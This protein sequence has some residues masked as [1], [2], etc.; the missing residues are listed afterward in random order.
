M[1][2][3]NKGI[4]DKK[5]VNTEYVLGLIDKYNQFYGDKVTQY[6]TNGTKQAADKIYADY[7]CNTY[8]KPRMLHETFFLSKGDSVSFTMPDNCIADISFDYFANSNGFLELDTYFNDFPLVVLFGQSASRSLVWAYNE[9]YTTLLN[10]SNSC[11]LYVRR[12][13]AITVTLPENVV[14]N[15][16]IQHFEIKTKL[17]TNEVLVDT[18]YMFGSTGSETDTTEFPIVETAT[19]NISF[20]YFTNTNNSTSSKPLRFSYKNKSGAE[21]VLF[22]PDIVPTETNFGTYDSVVACESGGK[23]VFVNKRVP[24]GSSGSAASFVQFLTI[25]GI[26]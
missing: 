22:E 2:I 23:L 15:A 20:F 3:R 14:G 19:Y 11:S 26:K 1:F 6:R 4:I 18:P 10:D 16:L 7:A 21:T 8:L 24:V 13:Q 12:G 9:R 5:I 17:K 25:R